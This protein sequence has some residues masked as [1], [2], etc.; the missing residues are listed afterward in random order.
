MEVKGNLVVLGHS[1]GLWFMES[2]FGWWSYLYVDFAAH[3]I[4]HLNVWNLCSTLMNINS[5]IKTF[6]R[7][8]KREN[9]R[10]ILSS[11]NKTKAVWQVINQETGNCPHNDCSILLWNF[12][13]LVTDCQIVSKRFNSFFVD[14]VDDLLN[15][16]NLY[17]IKQTSQYSMKSCSKTMF[18][19]PITET[20][21]VSVINSL[22]RCSS[23]GFDEISYFYWNAVY[24]IWK[25]PLHMYLIYLLILEFSQI[26]WK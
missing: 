14:T 20:E 7:F 23:A 24:I 12:T 10:Y 21:V 15:K 13:E 3:I 2:W 11:K 17:K 16:S 4:K 1:S 5:F 9:Y 18:A 25:N 8:K 22:K 19:S 6:E 26:W